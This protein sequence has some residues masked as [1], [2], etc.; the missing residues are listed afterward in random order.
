MCFLHFHFVV[1]SLFVS[2]IHRTLVFGYRFRP[3][4]LWLVVL[5]AF[6][7]TLPTAGRLMMLKPTHLLI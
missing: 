6:L 7:R 2:I 1:S 3:V 4:Q 5:L